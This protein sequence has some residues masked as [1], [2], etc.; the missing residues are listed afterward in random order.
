MDRPDEE[1][2]G[3]GL[4]ELEHRFDGVREEVDLQT[5]Q[6]RQA[7]SLGSENRVDVAVEGERSVLGDEPRGLLGEVLIR[8]VSPK[9]SKNTR[10]LN[11]SI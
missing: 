1:I 5:Q 4:Q 2:P 11:A 8:F 10:C 9:L 3:V 6:H 7:A